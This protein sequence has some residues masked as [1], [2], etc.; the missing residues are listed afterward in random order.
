MFRDYSCMETISMRV[1]YTSQCDRKLD[2]DSYINLRVAGPQE[3]PTL[4][5]MT[6]LGQNVSLGTPINLTFTL[7]TLS[8]KVCPCL[9]FV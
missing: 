1:H 5:C 6:L 7:K 4:A 9:N 3:S 2:D 8:S